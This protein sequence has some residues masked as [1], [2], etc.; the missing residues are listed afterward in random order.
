MDRVGNAN[1]A[2]EGCSTPSQADGLR[3]VVWR[4]GVKSVNNK[5][6]VEPFWLGDGENIR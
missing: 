3:E 2:S 5:L 4:Y 1:A 6:F